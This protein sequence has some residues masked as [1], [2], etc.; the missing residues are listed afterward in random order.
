LFIG[1]A[2][3][4]IVF[5]ENAFHEQPEGYALDYGF[6]AMLGWAWNC[7]YYET[8]ATSI[9]TMQWAGKCFLVLL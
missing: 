1:F 3:V 9:N 7:F 8:N 5:Y 6:I 2:G 4:A